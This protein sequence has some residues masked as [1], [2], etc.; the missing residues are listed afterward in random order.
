MSS[1]ERHPVLLSLWGVVALVITAIPVGI[2]GVESSWLVVVVW[3]TV[4]FSPL[5]IEAAWRSMRQ[6][7]MRRQPIQEDAGVAN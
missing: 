4:V 3:V 7:L 6:R 5:M 2:F 1:T